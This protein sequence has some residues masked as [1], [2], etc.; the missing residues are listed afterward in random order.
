MLQQL[1]LNLS[2]CDQPRAAE[3]CIR[4]S[5]LYQPLDSIFRFRVLNAVGVALH[6]CLGACV[7]YFNLWNSSLI[8]EV[9]WFD[10]GVAAWWLWTWGLGPDDRMRVARAAKQI[11]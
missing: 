1:H 9:P 2:G 4:G 10:F 11:C 6:I 7:A 3:L 5:A 8:T